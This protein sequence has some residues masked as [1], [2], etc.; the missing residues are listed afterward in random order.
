LRPAVVARAAVFLEPAVVARAA[1]FLEPAVVARAAVFLEP[2][3][4]ARAAVFLEPAAVVRAAVFVRPA[5]LRVRLPRAPRSGTSA[6]SRRASDSPMAIACL[7]LVTFRPV[8]PLRNVPSLRSRMVC[9]TLREAFL[10]YLRA[11]VVTPYSCR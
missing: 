7:R 9:S 6:P 10:L 3:A 11:I 5:A 4:V 8:L 2:A 1:V